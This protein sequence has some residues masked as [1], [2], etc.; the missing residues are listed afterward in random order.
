MN[1]KKKDFDEV[2]FGN[3]AVINNGCAFDAEHV[4]VTEHI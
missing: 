2:I 3:V 1:Q 4:F